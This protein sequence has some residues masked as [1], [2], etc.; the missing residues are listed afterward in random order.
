MYSWL[1]DTIREGFVQM[2]MNVKLLECTRTAVILEVEESQ[3]AVC[4]SAGIL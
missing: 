4:V 2:V 1:F 3:K